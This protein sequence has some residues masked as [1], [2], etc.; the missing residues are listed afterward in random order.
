M[1][2]SLM[3]SQIPTNEP[4]SEPT[5]VLS[6]VPSSSQSAQPSETPSSIVSLIPSAG[7]SS[8]PSVAPSTV[9][10]EAPSYDDSLLPSLVP[11]ARP[12][13]ELSSG[14]SDRPSLMPSSSPSDSLSADATVAP[15][16]VQQP[17]KTPSTSPTS[18]A[19]V[20]PSGKPTKAGPS[21]QPSAV[22]STTPLVSPSVDVSLQP[23]EVPSMSPSLMPSIETT[24]KQST[25]P[26]A[27][28][29]MEPSVLPTK[30]PSSGP[31]SLPSNCTN[32]CHSCEGAASNC[33]DPVNYQCTGSGVGTKTCRK[34]PTASPT[35]PGCDAVPSREPTEAPIASLS[36]ARSATTISEPS[37]KATELP[38][39]FPSTSPSRVPSSLPSEAPT[40]NQYCYVM[41]WGPDGSGGYNEFQVV[42]P[43]VGFPAEHAVVSEYSCLN[44][45][46]PIPHDGI[47]GCD[48]FT[49][50]NS[51][52]AFYSLG[53]PRGSSSNTGFETAEAVSLYFVVDDKRKGL[54]VINYDALNGTDSPNRAGLDISS[55]GLSGYGNVSFLV[56]DDESERKDWNS[57]DGSVVD[58]RW[59]WSNGK[60]DGAVLGY[61]PSNGFCLNL[62]WNVLRGIN[63]VQIGSYN[64]LT[65]QLEFSVSL[66]TESAMGANDIQA[67]AELCSDVCA[68]FNQTSCDSQFAC[69]WCNGSCMPDSDE[70]GDADDCDPCPFGTCA[71]TVSPG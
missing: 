67:C 17:S 61:L 56:Y 35:L 13:S 27:S 14:P 53:Q 44:A 7:P 4:S 24:Q 31:T 30:Q 60:T 28:P 15:S 32:A 37:N 6:S 49:A 25:T 50:A 9:P 3:P 46:D 2:P 21:K 57:L 18:K 41:K 29:S 8:G 34:R 43:L 20:F 62:H 51:A 33:C 36:L 48:G 52:E 54:F 58:A 71:P 42:R 10:S 19:S 23:S 64:A 5:A 26:S 12:S 1:I 47:T 22:P 66:S 11:S 45:G 63:S 40:L 65:I 39:Y 59:R 70:D 38:S 16:G 55:T 68:E 69:A